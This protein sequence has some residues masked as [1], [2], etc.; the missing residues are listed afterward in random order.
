MRIAI[1]GAGKIGEALLAGL[2][3]RTGPTPRRHVPARG[4]RAE[5]TERLGIEAT[6]RTPRRSRAPT[7]SCSP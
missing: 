2:R 3:T 1:L 5:L 4:A 7:S 6:T